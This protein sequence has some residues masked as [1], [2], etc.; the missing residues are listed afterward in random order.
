[1]PNLRLAVPFEEIQW[2]PPTRDVGIEKLPVE[3]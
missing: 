1:M 3:W 2:T